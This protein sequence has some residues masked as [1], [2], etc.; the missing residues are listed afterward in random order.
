LAD[1]FSNEQIVDDTPEDITL[2]TLVGENQKYRTPDDLAKAYSHADAAINA[3]KAR[4]AELEAADRVKTDLLEARLKNQSTPSDPP[5]RQDTNLNPRD[6]DPAAK[7]ETPDINKLVRDE[8]ANASE[9]KRRADN[10]NAAAEAM[11]DHYGS[12]AKAQEAIQRRAR[13]LNVSVEWLRDAASQ[14][15]PAFLATMGLTGE[16]PR[17]TPGVSN[18]VNLTN[19]NRGGMKNFKYYDDIRKK[20]PKVYYSGEMQRQMFEARRELGDKFFTT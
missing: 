9:E 20:S 17:A 10:I 18:E 1:P 14:S 16:R 6:P 13:E 11:N 15:A 8:L 3:A 12:P 5:A 4:I 7:V 2:D 19:A